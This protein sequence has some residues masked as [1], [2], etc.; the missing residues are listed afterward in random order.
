MAEINK[1]DIKREAKEFI[2][3]AGD[4]AQAIAADVSSEAKEIAA[5]VAKEAKDFAANPQ[6]EAREAF[7]E[8]KQEAA[9]VVQEAR[10]AA[11]GQPLNTANTVGGAGYRAP[12]T[13]SNGLGVASLV[14]GILSIVCSFIP[15]W[16]WILALIMGLIGTVLGAKARKESQTGVATGGFVCS[17]IGLVF[18]AVGLVCVACIG[19]AGAAGVFNAL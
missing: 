16:G 5:D 17:I 6:A 18:G 10:A 2:D 7:A 13:Q 8:V 4:K 19:V 1:E 9:E 15:A 3:E 11:T 12:N 14:L